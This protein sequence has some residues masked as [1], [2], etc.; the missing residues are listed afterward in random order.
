M[1]RGILAT[2]Y[3]PL[4]SDFIENNADPKSK[5]TEFTKFL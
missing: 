1:T 4:S 3:A 5:I 2:C